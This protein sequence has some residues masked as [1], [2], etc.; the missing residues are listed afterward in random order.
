MSLSSGHALKKKK[1]KN[2]NKKHPLGYPTRQKD[3][4]DL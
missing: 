1:E 2:K 3:A 4:L